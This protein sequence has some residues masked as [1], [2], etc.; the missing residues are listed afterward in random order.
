MSRR[1][2]FPAVTI[3][4]ILFVAAVFVSMY[5]V[6][7][8]ST[9]TITAIST[10]GQLTLAIPEEALPQHFDSHDVNITQ[11]NQTDLP[12]ELVELNFASLYSLEPGGTEFDAPVQIS[13]TIDQID[14]VVPL[15][16]HFDGQ[17]ISLPE[18]L[19]IKINPDQSAT[20]SGEIMS[21][22]YIGLM[23]D[24]GWP[25]P[26]IVGMSDDLGT[27][28]VGD[29][30]VARAD[31]TKVSSTQ[32]SLGPIG[33]I[34]FGGYEVQIDPDSEAVFTLV[35]DPTIT[36]Q[37]SA[38]T[39]ISPEIF[40]SAPPLMKLAGDG[41]TEFRTFTCNAVG[42]GQITYQVQSDVTLKLETYS[43]SGFG[44]DYVEAFFNWLIAEEQNFIVSG[45]VASSVNCIEP[46]VNPEIPDLQVKD[47]KISTACGGIATFE[48]R[49]FG[50]ISEID[51]VQVMTQSNETDAVKHS[52]LFFPDDGFFSTIA[53]LPPG[54]YE[55]HL[56]VIKH[57]G[58]AL[59]QKLGD[60]TIEPCEESAST[61]TVEQE[62]SEPV[63]DIVDDSDNET[64]VIIPPDETETIIDDQE[65]PEDIVDDDDE[66]SI[67][68][69]D[70]EDE[71]AQETTEDQGFV[72]CYDTNY[73]DA[74]YFWPFPGETCA[75]YGA[76]QVDLPQSECVNDFLIGE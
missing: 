15:M 52:T 23:T 63:E 70:D 19:Q 36:G 11:L 54:D 33:R 29:E 28:F 25:V 26:V 37:F 74:P 61:G 50:D 71:T 22:S 73:P 5:L 13:M 3:I 38:T 44:S 69:E 20:I 4:A 59:G 17:S 49:I 7:R 72:C 9:T 1:I 47:L 41:Y 2:I 18:N 31:V 64:T 45:E 35:D 34:E 24:I 46:I 58:D 30:F 43:R 10:D 6:F 57:S 53:N 68:T 65:P 16:V 48:G 39:P 42:Q 67:E 66:E 60:F 32:L 55:Y 75:D 56:I 27:Y 12:T 21:F 8:P 62:D 51:Y 76:I 14:Q 40:T